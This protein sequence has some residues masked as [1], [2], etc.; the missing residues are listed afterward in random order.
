M[1]ARSPV[2]VDEEG[3]QHEKAEQ[4]VDDRCDRRGHRDIEP[5][6]VDLREE[7]AVRH[8]ARA[9]VA[10]RRRD[11]GKR[12]HSGRDPECVRDVDV[13]AGTDVRQAAEDRGEDHDRQ[14]RA[15]N[16]PRRTEIR[17]PVARLDVPQ[18]EEP[19]ELPVPP[20]L[21]EVDR[22]EPA[23]R[24]DSMY[25]DRVWRNGLGFHGLHAARIASAPASRDGAGCA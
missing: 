18:D 24:L 23:R 7:V 12:K 22:N 9:R 25:A 6:E 19:H 1:P 2:E 16:R 21:A 13:L 14:Q 11:V 20:E 15:Q 17:L 4:E 5:R 8:E 10:Q 3:E